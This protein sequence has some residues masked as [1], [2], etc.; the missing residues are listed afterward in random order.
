MWGW[1]QSTGAWIGDK[2]NAVTNGVSEWAGGVGTVPMRFGTLQNRVGAKDGIWS[3]QTDLDEIQDVGGLEGLSLDRE[4]S[5]NEVTMEVNRNTGVLTLNANLAINSL[6][7]EGLTAQSVTLSDVHIEVEN[8]SV[9][10][11]FLGTLSAKKGGKTNAPRMSLYAQETLL[12][13]A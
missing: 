8:A 6:A 1:M 4:A 10:A 5:D 11:E 9:N 13:G 7:F 2:Y 12:V 3:L